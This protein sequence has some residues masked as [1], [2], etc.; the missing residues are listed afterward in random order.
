MAH[1]SRPRLFQAPNKLVRK[2]SRTFIA[3]PDS[4]IELANLFTTLAGIG[5][6]LLA[7]SFMWAFRDTLPFLFASQF[8]YGGLLFFH[9]IAK[10]LSKNGKAPLYALANALF[11]PV[12]CHM[13]IASTY[14]TLLFLVFV[15]W[16]T[17]LLVRQKRVTF[18]LAL[19]TLVSTTAIMSVYWEPVPI[20]NIPV[21]RK[22]FLESSV[23]I[24]LLCLITLMFG[25]VSLAFNRIDAKLNHLAESLRTQRNRA[26]AAL[27]VSNRFLAMISHEFRTPVSTTAL[28]VQNLRSRSETVAID[29]ELQA[30]ER[31]NHTLL[32]FFNNALNYAKYTTGEYRPELEPVN[33]RSLVN[34]LS[35]ILLPKA[36]QK[37]LALK[38]DIDAEYP[39]I[40]LADPNLIRL[41]TSN[42]MDNAIKFT[43]RGT[44]SA[45]I[46][47]LEPAVGSPMMR[48]EIKDTGRGIPAEDLESIFNL[49]RSK[50]DVGIEPGSGWRRSWSNHMQKPRSGVRRQVRCGKQAQ[51]RLHFLV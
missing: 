2:Y 37:G 45:C 49:F 41:V 19:T 39:A 14:D 36:L 25:L 38:I 24:Y 43:D 8:A 46:R 50:T 27:A 47:L 31:A 20:D 5:V 22:D 33:I 16:G 51:P 10:K 35:G 29:R 30:I 9:A 3:N 12:S 34:D 40:I 11:N 7:G 32:S 48:T 28:T 17:V 44:V 4:F 6:C 15:S 13:A 23:R 21:D 42:L 26:R 1:E 18:Y